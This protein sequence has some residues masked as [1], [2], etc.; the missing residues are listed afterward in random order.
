MKPRSSLPWPQQPATVVCPKPDDTSQFSHDPFA[1]HILP[2]LPSTPWSPNFSVVF[3][4]HVSREWRWT[5]PSDTAAFSLVHIDRRFGGT[6]FFLF[7]AVYSSTSLANSFQATVLSNV[8]RRMSESTVLLPIHFFLPP[9]YIF[10]HFHPPLLS[11]I[12]MV[13]LLIPAITY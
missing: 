6:Y 11:H 10:R 2:V 5:V 9:C 12:V 7:P 13:K 8:W 1:K 4:F 3:I